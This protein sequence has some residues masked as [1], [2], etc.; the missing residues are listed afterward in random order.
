MKRVRSRSMLYS[1]F[2]S[3]GTGFVNDGSYGLREF[4]KARLSFHG[5][6]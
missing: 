4:V 2:L 6:K 3:S 5:L 1:T